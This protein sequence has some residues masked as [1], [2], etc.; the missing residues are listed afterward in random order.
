MRITRYRYNNIPLDMNGRYIYIKLEDDKIVS[1]MYKP[2][3][4]MPKNKEMQHKALESVKKYL[5]TKHGI[6]ILNPAYSKYYLNLGEIS[7]YPPGYKENGGRME[8][9]LDF[10]ERPY[11]PQ[12][13]VI[14]LDEKPIQL[15]SDLKE[16]IPIQEGRIKKKDYEYKKIVESK[17]WRRKREGN[18]GA[19][20]NTPT[21]ASWLN[22]AEIEISIYFNQCLGKRRI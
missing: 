16:P 5:A 3:M 13:T 1:P 4:V 18:L 9:L 17:I 8:D 10:Y 20:Y 22:Q 11:N 7:T 6:V 19:F 14:C 21:H 15:L 12:E 2:S